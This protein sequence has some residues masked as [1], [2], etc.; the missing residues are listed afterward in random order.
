MTPNLPLTRRTIP[1]GNDTFILDSVDDEDALL[2]H[3]ESATHFPFGLM[4]WESAIA[5][6]LHLTQNPALAAGKSVLE[7]GAGLGLT[8]VVAASLGATVTQTDHDQTALDA[9]ARTAAL[10]GITNITRPPGDW[11]AWT[12]PSRY[13]LILGA[14]IAYDAENHAALLAIFDHALA[15]GGRILLT[16][17]HRENLPPFIAAARTAGWSVTRTNTTVP[18]LKA[19]TN[20]RPIALL[21]LHRS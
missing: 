16:D 20:P 5:L 21:D 9:C 1:I 7:L 18:D 3:A 6:A 14:D 11:H 12:D 4:L 13:D 19:P 17:P 8:G 15:P 2:A 10:N